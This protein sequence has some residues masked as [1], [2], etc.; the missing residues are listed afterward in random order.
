LTLLATTKAISKSGSAAR[1]GMSS[2]VAIDS[3]HIIKSTVSTECNIRRFVAA[4]TA[5]EAKT[6]LLGLTPGTARCVTAEA[7]R[8]L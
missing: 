1:A 3:R 6:V 7:N 2:E 8:R 5:A 4:A